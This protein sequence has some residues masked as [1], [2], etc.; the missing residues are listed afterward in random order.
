VYFP[1]EATHTISRKG[2]GKA[3][4]ARKSESLINS[5]VKVGSYIVHPA[6]L[7]DLLG[8]IRTLL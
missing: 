5:P 2:S 6:L 8:R 3:R 7:L 1:V 4:K